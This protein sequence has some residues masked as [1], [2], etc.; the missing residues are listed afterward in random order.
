MRRS[1]EMSRLRTGAGHGR[2][3]GG[4][5][6]APDSSS[7]PPIRQLGPVRRCEVCAWMRPPSLL[8]VF[9]AGLRALLRARDL[10]P[11]EARDEGPTGHAQQLGCATLISRAACQRLQ[12]PLLVGVGRAGRIELVVAGPRPG[13]TGGMLGAAFSQI[14]IRVL[15]YLWAGHRLPARAGLG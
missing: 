4:P 10:V 9:G 6:L 13:W 15:G 8:W 12:D 5:P 2:H 1:P 3:P 7:A 11:I 14:P